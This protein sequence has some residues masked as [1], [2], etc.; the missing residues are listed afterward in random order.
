MGLETIE[1]V[2][3]IENHFL[4]PIPDEEAKKMYTI[5]DISNYIAKLSGADAERTMQIEQEVLAL[6]S[7]HAGVDRADLQLDMSITND[8]GLD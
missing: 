5:R 7:S 6:V 2:Y 1:L 4:L 8:L 3:K